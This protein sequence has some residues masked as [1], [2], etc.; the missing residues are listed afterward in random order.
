ME[1]RLS[2]ISGTKTLFMRGIV[3]QIKYGQAGIPVPSSS[4]DPMIKIIHLEPVA[5][6]S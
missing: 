3:F 2:T 6:V 5:Q 4:K 1:N